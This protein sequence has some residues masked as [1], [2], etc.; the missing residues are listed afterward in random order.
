MLKFLNPVAI[1][2]KLVKILITT[3]ILLFILGLILPQNLII[4]VEGASQKDWNSKSFWYYPWGKSI[5][6]KGIDIFA[7]SGTNILSSCNGII[8]YKGHIKYGGNII[9]ILGPK[10]R[11]HYYAHL[12]ETNVERHTLVRKGSLLGTV[13]NSGNAKN[14]PAHLHYTIKTIIPYPWKIDNDKQGWKKMFYLNPIDYL[15]KKYK[16]LN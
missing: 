6:H 11:L 14:T 3:A 15:P 13:G 7:D 10:W 12:K 8:L 4:P 1:M 2:K 9:L 5:T 16:H